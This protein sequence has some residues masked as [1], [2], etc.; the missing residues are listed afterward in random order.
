MNWPK[1]MLV[2]LLVCAA[3]AI[4]AQTPAQSYDLERL[5]M[6]KWR[7]Q[8]GPYVTV[9]VYTLRGSY[10]EFTAVT[11]QRGAPYRLYV[12]GEW[13]VN[14]N[15]DLWTYPKR[16]EPSDVRMFAEGTP[17]QVIDYNH[18]RN[19]LGDVYRVR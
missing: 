8:Y 19:K 7:Q 17:I 1:R 4:L 14:N 15:R 5:L 13:R 3:A 12:V 11:V 2:A 16:W 18:F 9:A 6:G 10:H